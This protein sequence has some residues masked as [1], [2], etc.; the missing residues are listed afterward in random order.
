MPKSRVTQWAVVTEEKTP[1]AGGARPSPIICVSG[2]VEQ[3]IL[4]VSVDP[5]NLLS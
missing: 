3:I 5:A 4:R 1:T 2:K